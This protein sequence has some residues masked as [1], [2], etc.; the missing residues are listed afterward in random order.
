MFSKDVIAA[1]QQ[2]G[3]AEY[4]RESCGLVVDG[5]YLPCLNIAEDPEKSFEIDGDLLPKLG[6]RI[7]GLIHSHP[8]DWPVPSAKDMRQQ[9]A[10]DIPWGIVAV[11]FPKDETGQNLKSKKAPD[12]L[13]VSRPVWFGRQVP[14]GPL[15]G[16]GFCHGQSDCVSLILD[17]HAYQGIE[18]PEPP[19][20]W[21]W[22]LQGGDL[23]RDNFA[24]YGF[25]VCD[26]M[27][28]GA[29]FMVALGED[30]NRKPIMVP[31][32]AGIYLGNNLALH[33][34]T[35]RQAVDPS[36]LSARQPFGRWGNYFNAP[37]MWV[38]HRD[39]PLKLKPV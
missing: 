23:Y 7:E 39:L 22:W 2:H 9:Q 3:R 26:P 1:A 21:E 29:V 32:H 5:E 18:M 14:K 33:H 27:I 16:R 10:M 35:A 8:D 13:V 4:P 38:R 24:A 6:N 34:L 17:W 30:A 31:N 15:I 11:D 37:P 36:R 25:E 12:D 19:R 28:P 20:D